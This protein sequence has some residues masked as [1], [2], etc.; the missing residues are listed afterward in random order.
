MSMRWARQESNLHAAGYE[1]D[2]LTVELRA[3]IA[4]RVARPV[5]CAHHEGDTARVRTLALL[6]A[7][8][9]SLALADEI[10]LS[11]GS[12]R[13]R[14]EPARWILRAEAGNEFAPYGYVGACVSWMIDPNDEIELGAGGGF[15]G[16]QLGF[17]VRRLFG[18]GGQYLLAELF[19]AG[20]TRV[21][22]GVEKNSAQINA[23]AASADSSLWTGL[24]L[25]FEQRLS[26][27]S[28]S[29]AGNIVFTSTS[30]SPH[31]SV[32]GGLGVGF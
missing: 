8:V 5:A 2:A 4:H 19:L 12:R 24:G 3:P 23:A 30:L 9:P 7:L 1:P 20:N 13:D 25:G 32:H 6:V 27:F 17:A 21:N 16:L 10:D 14:G 18:D 29:A 28:F 26:F 31:W 22:R 11:R 15:P